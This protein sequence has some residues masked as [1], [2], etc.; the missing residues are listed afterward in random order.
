MSPELEQIPVVLLAAGAGKRMEPITDHFPKC[1]VPV[2]NQPILVK[3]IHQYATAGCK[4]FI[5]VTNPDADPEIRRVIKSANLPGTVEFVHQE[6]PQGMADAI[7]VVESL[8][9][10]E[11]DAFVVTATDVL[12]PQ[13]ALEAFLTDARSPGRHITLTLTQ[14][15]DEAVAAGHANVKVNG[16]G[17]VTHIVEKP[18]PD[19]IVSTQYSLPTYAFSPAIFEHLRQTPVSARGEREVQDAI[20]LA[21]EE[22]QVVKGVSLLPGS[23]TR[24]TIGK[25]HVTTIADYLRMNAQHLQAAPRSPTR[26]EMPTILGKVWIAP[27]ARVDDSNL[28]GPNTVIHA[29]HVGDYCEISGSIVFNDAVLGK[30][31]RLVNSIVL[32]GCIVPG[33]TT[34]SSQVGFLDAAGQFQQQ[35]IIK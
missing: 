3:I 24:T 19:Q 22:G 34:L 17:Q 33:E 23:T 28:L 8:I 21:I 35:E 20:K 5:C 30:D 2:V 16:D 1:L 25:Y 7:A 32:P 6:K 12:Y 15:S 4:R 27:G 10:P 26:G 31:C 18:A 9:P 14:S 11:T 29:A 13:A